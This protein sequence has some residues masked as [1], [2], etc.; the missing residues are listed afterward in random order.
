MFAQTPLFMVQLIC[1]CFLK[2]LPPLLEQ[3]FLVALLKYN[4]RTIRVTLKS[5]QFGGFQSLHRVVRLSP[6][7]SLE[8]F[9]HLESH[10]VPFSH[11]TSTCFTPSP[12]ALGSFSLIFCLDRFAYS[13]HFWTGRLMQDV[14]LQNQ[15]FCLTF[16]HLHCSICQDS[17]AF[18]RVIFLVIQSI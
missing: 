11:S 14:I 9:H 17:I 10:R 18:Y 3:Y 1:Q 6:P 15:H 13:G 8:H 16:F 12:Q 4:S 7:S 5:I 2:P